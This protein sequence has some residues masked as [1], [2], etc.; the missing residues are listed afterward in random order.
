[1]GG[2]GDGGMFLATKERRL[3][4][5]EKGK[6]KQLQDIKRAKRSERSKKQDKPTTPKKNLYSSCAH[7][8]KPFDTTIPEVE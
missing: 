7:T 1:M 6:G 3:D 5:Y 8:K 4:M 2:W